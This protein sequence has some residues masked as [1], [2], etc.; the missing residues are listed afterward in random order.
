[1]SRVAALSRQLLKMFPS[2]LN[3]VRWQ[4]GCQRFC[5]RPFA[6]AP[7]RMVLDGGLAAS[8]LSILAK[9]KKKKKIMV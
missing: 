6:R 7:I 4:P 1:M 2:H 8:V 5:A 3:G 9:K